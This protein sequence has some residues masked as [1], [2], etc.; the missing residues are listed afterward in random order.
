MD[1]LLLS[2]P[3]TAR[4]GAPQSRGPCAPRSHQP[5][6]LPTWVG[7]GQG[8]RS[9][10]CQKCVSVE[11]RPPSP[12]C[13]RAQPGSSWRMKQPSP[14]PSTP[15]PNSAGR[16]LLPSAGLDRHGRGQ[17]VGTWL[18]QVR[19]G[20]YPPTE[21]SGKRSI[22]F[23]EVPSGCQALALFRDKAHFHMLKCFLSLRP[24]YLPTVNAPQPE[25][26]I[27]GG[28]LEAQGG[29]VTITGTQGLRKRK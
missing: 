20:W 18:E 23:Q 26:P 2:G 24:N 13:N 3:S 11:P 14:S 9:S 22:A 12:Q 19:T 28:H 27:C 1:P 29:E 15:L 4:G 7:R 17:A 25:K 5:W 6:F 16:L 10:W 8:L 21:L